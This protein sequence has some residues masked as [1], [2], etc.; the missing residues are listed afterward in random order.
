VGN[1]RK[2]HFCVHRLAE[3]LLPA[4]VTTCIGRATIFGNCKDSGSLVSE[5]MGSP[6]VHLLREELGTRPAV[7]YLV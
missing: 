2:C 3:G 4:C 7:Y 5:L 6:R 1:A